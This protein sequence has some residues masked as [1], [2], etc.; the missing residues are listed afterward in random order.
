M[1]GGY[2]MKIA[3]CDDDKQELLQISRLVNEYLNC[4]F[5]EDQIKVLRFENSMELINQIEGG[6]HFDVFLL[7]IMMPNISG[8]ELAAQIRSNDKVAKIIFLT[9]SPEFAV[10]SYSVGAFNYLLK[11]IQ[12]GTLFSALEKACNDICSGL[13][14]Y[15]IVKTQTSL[16]KVF[17]HELI[18]VE[19]I[20]RT[21]YFY[22]KNGVAIESNSS[23]SK[24]EAALL[25]DNSFIKPHRSYIVNLD[26]IKN[27]SKDG[28][29]MTNGQVIPIS[30]NVFK[31][32]KQVYIDYSFQEEGGR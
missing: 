31:E 21:S 11:P 1:M 13:K 29:M 5:A 27:L 2:I 28:L 17:F 32:I 12:K 30:R 20:G 4:G 16:S 9:S 14:Q 25:T 24:F 6:K 23:I 15:I 22:Q 19:V 8:M 26:Y 18:C 10:D 7:D 3:I